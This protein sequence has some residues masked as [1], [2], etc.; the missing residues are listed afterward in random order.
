MADHKNIFGGYT[1]T[2]GPQFITAVH[3]QHSCW[4]VTKLSFFTIVLYSTIAPLLTCS[5]VCDGLVLRLTLRLSQLSSSQSSVSQVGVCMNSQW[6]L[7]DVSHLLLPLSV[8]SGTD[9]PNMQLLHFSDLWWAP[10]MHMD[11]KVQFIHSMYWNLL[12]SEKLGRKL[13]KIWPFSCTYF[14]TNYSLKSHHILEI[15]MVVMVY[16]VVLGCNRM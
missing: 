15:F 8:D 1:S 3:D 9:I 2:H 13:I 12:S 7:Y 16:T 6:H 10:E 14:M 4:Y 5:V 11:V